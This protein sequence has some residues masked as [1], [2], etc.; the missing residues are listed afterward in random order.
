M[1]TIKEVAK[2]AGVSI[3]TVSRAL[4]GKVFVEEAT[5][6]R[7]LKA[8]KQLAYR[9][10]PLAKGLKDG[11]SKTLALVLP[12]ILNPFFPTMIKYLERHAAAHGYSL[13]LYDSGED[14][15]Q[16]KRAME[17]LRTHYVD[18]VLY[19]PIADD[20]SLARM[21]RDAGVPVMVLNRESDGIVPAVA[22]DNRGGARMVVDYLIKQGHRKI[23]CFTG[24]LKHRRYS[25]RH[26]GCLDAF[27]AARIGDQS[28][29]LIKNTRTIETA[30]ARAKK[31]FSRRDRP[32]AVFVFY[33]MLALGVYSGAN[34]CGLRIPDDI[35][36]AGFDN[37][38]L[39]EHLLPPLTTYEQPMDALAE[40]AIAGLLDQMAGKKTGRDVSV[41]VKGGL[42]IRKSVRALGAKE[43]V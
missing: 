1:S 6:D 42:V 8:V 29:Y 40:R 27:K 4:S 5:R 21:L 13:I 36:I 7:V 43:T 38:F 12:D 10:N 26:E 28:S 31:L 2:L 9:P 39:A 25:Q 16:E 19:S 15:R 20:L 3:S 22:N 32:T 17:S 24:D 33:D 41:L 14:A 37:I 35:S 34:D 23:A 11:Q 18:G 30:Y